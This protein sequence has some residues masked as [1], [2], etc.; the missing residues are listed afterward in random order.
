M[1][2]NEVT[3]T[4]RIFEDRIL[5]MPAELSLRSDQF[6]YFGTEQALRDYDLTPDEILSGLVDG[7]GDGGIDALYTFTNGRLQDDYDIPADLPSNYALDLYIVQAK[8]GSFQANA[9]TIINENVHKLL[10][11]S[12]R[13]MS[14]EY[15]TRLI[16]RIGIFRK[17]L[18]ETAVKYPKIHVHVIYPAIKSTVRINARVHQKAADLRNNIANIIGGD[19]VVDIEF[20]GAGEL[21]EASSKQ[22]SETFELK[23]KDSIFTEHGY[24]ALVSIN[25]FGDFITDSSSKLKRY[26]FD[27]NVRDYQGRTLVNKAIL[28][29]LTTQENAADFWWLNNGITILSDQVSSV[30]RKF[31]IKDPQI[32]NGLQ[33]SESIFKYLSEAD[34]TSDE[35]R[36]VMVKIIESGVEDVRNTVIIATNSQNSLSPAAIRAGDKIQK[37][38][39]THFLSEGYFYDRRKNHY[40]NKGEPAAKIF[41]IQYLAQA[42]MAI[43]FR[44]PAEARAS[45]SKVIKSDEDYEKI[46]SSRIELSNYLWMARLQRAVDVKLRSSDY[47][48]EFKSN[49]RFYLSMLIAR[50]LA[51]STIDHPNQLSSISNTAPIIDAVFDDTAMLLQQKMTA[52]QREHPDT[53]FDT[54]SKSRNFAEYLDEPE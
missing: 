22:Q 19:V 5:R 15:N 12:S 24:L 53:N 6:V 17:L 50:Q 42:T 11:L 2:D 1:P 45:P 44:S 8:E 9:L 39:E 31:I 46:F 54:I 52:Y 16:D 30:S 34:D 49:A 25:D 10:N 23:F 35:S 48:Q 21:L 47:P 40:K 37:L 7:D 32:V 29:S 43:G 4:K 3:L 51:G 41:G 26:M 36:M 27:A 38:I 14:P 33:T 20:L 13:L 28:D 18:D